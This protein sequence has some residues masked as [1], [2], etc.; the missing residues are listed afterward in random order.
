MP[1]LGD[2]KKP[3]LFKYVARPASV[4]NSEVAKA[5]PVYID[6]LPA[7]GATD[8]GDIDGLQSIIE[9]FEQRIAGLE[10]AAEG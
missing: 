7:G 2:K 5:R 9:D 4:G 10:A 3:Q 8:I 1:S 6:G